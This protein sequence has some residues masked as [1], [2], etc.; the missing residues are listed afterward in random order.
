MPLPDLE[1]YP[2]IP[3]PK[4]ILLHIDCTTMLPEHSKNPI[5]IIQMGQ[6]A[7][8]TAVRKSAVTSHSAQLA[9]HEM[10]GRPRAA[11]DQFAVLQLLGGQAVAVLVLLD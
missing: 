1:W 11:D 2:R 4:C 3:I 8:E 5:W 7:A 10:I 9:R 6:E